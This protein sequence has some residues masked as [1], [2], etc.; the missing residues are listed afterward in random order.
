MS[1]FTRLIICG[2]L[3]VFTIATGIWVSNVGKA[4][5]TGVLTV[6]KLTALVCVVFLFVVVRGLLNGVQLYSIIMVLL[7]ITI[8]SIIA[9][10]V[11][12]V[13]LSINKHVPQIILII[14]AF[15]PIVTIV[16]LIIMTAFA[17]NSST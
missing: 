7:I 8:L 4:I 16:S 2:I 1:L 5:V 17:L 3:I 10:F 6:H 14:H 11:S 9:L 12:G 13:L 15:T